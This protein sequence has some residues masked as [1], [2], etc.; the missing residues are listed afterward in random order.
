MDIDADFL[1]LHLADSALPTG[2]F[3]HSFG[4]ETYLSDDR[5][6]DAA[7]FRDWLQVLLRV[8]LTSADALAIRLYYAAPGPHTVAR[9]DERLHAG[10][11]AREV[12]EANTRMGTRLAEIVTET[13]GFPAVEEYLADIRGRRLSGHP[14]LVLAMAAHAT[15]INVERAVLAHLTATVSSLVQNAV[16]GIPLGQMAGQQVLYRMY[17]DITAAVQR[18]AELGEL[19]LCSGDPGLDISQMIHETQRARLFMS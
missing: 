17:P 16:R 13:Y 10:T 14:A 3:A 4:F 6:T 7:Q 5:I 2:A 18:S 12:R 15:G 1:L 9:L 19:D 11:P 8:Q